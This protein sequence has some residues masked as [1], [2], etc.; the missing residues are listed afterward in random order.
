MLPSMIEL[1]FH[2]FYF[3]LTGFSSF[4][5]LTKA[6]IFLTDKGL[7][8]VPSLNWFGLVVLSPFHFLQS[9]FWDVF[10]KHS[11]SLLSI[12]H[13]TQPLPV[14][15]VVSCWVWHCLQQQRFRK[16]GSVAVYMVT[17]VPE[18]SLVFN[19]I[20]EAILLSIHLCS[21]FWSQ[22]LV[23]CNVN[24]VISVGNLFCTEA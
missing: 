18:L 13:R 15:P 6:L 16:M 8:L 3:L 24:F 12:F 22:T 4:L 23:N 7:P 19:P 2:L 10:S 20:L 5:R 17:W 21:L 1:H 14:V 9:F 11:E